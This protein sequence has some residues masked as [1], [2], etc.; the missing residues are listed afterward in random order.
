MDSVYHNLKERFKVRPRIA[1]A[2]V[3]R[4][5][6]PLGGGAGAKHDLHRLFP[7]GDCLGAAGGQSIL[8]DIVN[9]TG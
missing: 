8:P 7:D 9:F 3:L 2:G 6:P 5:E 4:E 1:R